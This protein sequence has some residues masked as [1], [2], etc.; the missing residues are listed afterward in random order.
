MSECTV[1]GTAKFQ[2]VHAWDTYVTGQGQFLSRLQ[3]PAAYIQPMHVQSSLEP[4]S[5]LPS[6]NYRYCILRGVKGGNIINIESDTHV[7]NMH[8]HSNAPPSCHTLQSLQSG[9]QQQTH[10]IN[11]ASVC[12]F[13][14]YLLFGLSLVV[15]SAQISISLMSN[16]ETNH[17]QL[18]CSP[19]VCHVS[20]SILCEQN[21]GMLRSKLLAEPVSRS[22]P[23]AYVF[24]LPTT[25]S[26]QNRRPL[27][28]TTRRTGHNLHS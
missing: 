15:P 25:H 26:P 16:A 7:C 23:T 1:Y 20:P 12:K 5:C 10:D 28:G 6:N 4:E 21:Q 18:L 9:A 17:P 8:I 19:C 27:L 13:N 24:L 2:H 11:A 22:Q 3:H 14:V